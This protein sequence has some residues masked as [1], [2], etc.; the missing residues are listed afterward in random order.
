MA[1]KKKKKGGWV[2]LKKGHEIDL[3]NGSPIDIAALMSK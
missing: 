2:D 3:A 1:G